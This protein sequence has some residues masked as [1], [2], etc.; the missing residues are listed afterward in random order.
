MSKIATR[1]AYGKTLARLVVQDDHIFVLDA[2]LSGSTKTA[3]A[4]KARPE[5]HFNMG[6]AEG[7]MMSV[8]AGMA[9]QGNVV[10]ASSFAMFATG[11]A[12]EQIRNSIA[13]PKLNVKI[14]A[15]HA[16]VT[17]G[18]DG[19]SH[20]TVEDISL[21]RSIPNMVVLCP[22][23]AYEAEAAIEAVYR[24]NGPCFVRLGRSA[25][26]TIY[27]EGK[28]SF[29]IGKGTMLH[30]GSKV[31]LIAC[32]IMVNEALQAY[33]ALKAEGIEVTVI[34][35][36]SIKPID[37]DLIIETANTHDVIITIEEH[38]VIGGLGSAVS[39]VLSQYAPCRQIMMG[40]PDCFG[41]SGTPDA[42][43]EKFHLQAKDIAAE[44]KEQL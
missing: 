29:T 4:K 41:E 20:Q 37:R 10:F 13:Y 2:D 24:Y 15:S 17:V 8:A 23:D 30:K 25:V 6:I 1:E 3:M 9:A 26:P 11:R 39:E 33:E 31:A 16:G 14:C 7:N 22:A 27:E 12:F 28:V 5:C 35:M 21:M 19:A 36:A 34:D 40:I 42:L 43:L 32:G 18:E 44:V 38:S